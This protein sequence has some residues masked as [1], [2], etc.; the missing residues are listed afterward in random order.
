VLNILN[1]GNLGQNVS[2]RVRFH[3]PLLH[4]LIVSKYRHWLFHIVKQIFH[5]L[6]AFVVS[7]TNMKLTIDYD[8]VL[9]ATETTDRLAVVLQAEIMLCLHRY[10]YAKCVFEG[11][12]RCH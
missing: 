3:Q 7:V 12:Y 8:D 10:I 6:A 2:G 5:N 1:R 9:F 4:V 11:Q